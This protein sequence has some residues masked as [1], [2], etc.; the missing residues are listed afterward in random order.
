MDSIN[1]MFRRK[2]FIVVLC[3]AH[4]T[5][6]VGRAICRGSEKQCVLLQLRGCRHIFPVAVRIQVRKEG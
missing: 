6:V 3:V 1:K 2:F 4:G 5:M